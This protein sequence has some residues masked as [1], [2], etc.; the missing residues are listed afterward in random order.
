MIT[1]YG[2]R[3]RDRCAWLATGGNGPPVRKGQGRGHPAWLELKNVESESTRSRVCSQGE[4]S[5]IKVYCE[6]ADPV[7]QQQPAVQAV[8]AA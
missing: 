2:D 3:P 8:S 4:R 7:E 5:A 6:V 1:V